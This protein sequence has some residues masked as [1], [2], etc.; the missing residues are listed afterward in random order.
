M[1]GLDKLI[2]IPSEKTIKRDLEGDK[3]AKKYFIAL[4]VIKDKTGSVKE[5]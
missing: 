5:K 4:G 2:K 3:K 1:A